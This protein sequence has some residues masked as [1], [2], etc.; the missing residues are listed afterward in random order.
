LRLLGA[1]ACCAPVSHC[2]VP[3]ASGCTYVSV[4]PGFFHSKVVFYWRRYGLLFVDSYAT[5]PWV[6]WPNTPPAGVPFSPSADLVGY[7][8]QINANA[9]PPGI[10][11]DTWY[12]SWAPDGKL[13]SSWTDGVVNGVE[14]NSALGES[15]SRGRRACPHGIPRACLPDSLPP[16]WSPTSLQSRLPIVVMCTLFLYGVSV[17]RAVGCG[18]SMV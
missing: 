3:W 17:Y 6:A 10:K 14:S 11:A 8:Y 12:P 16:P 7:S 9:V 4:S 1:L 18:R 2:A 15:T 13:Y 5:M